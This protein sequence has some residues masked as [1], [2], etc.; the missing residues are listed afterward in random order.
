MLSITNHQ[1]MQIKPQKHH[2]TLA[3]MTKNDRYILV[4]L[5]RKWN[6]QFVGRNDEWCSH[7]G[8]V[9]QFCRRLNHV[10]Q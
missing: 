1:K 5:W 3:W 2:L 8:K 6:L 9:L 7:F 10:T 4:K